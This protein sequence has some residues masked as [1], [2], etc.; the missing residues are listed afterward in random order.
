MQI[1][2]LDTSC[3]D[4]VKFFNQTPRHPYTWRGTFGFKAPHGVVH[5]FL[6][7]TSY[8]LFKKER[9]EWP[10]TP[11]GLEVVRPPPVAK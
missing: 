1:N 11:F 5:G 2:L 10:A 8:F 9:V 7:A 3:Q 6:G 4:S